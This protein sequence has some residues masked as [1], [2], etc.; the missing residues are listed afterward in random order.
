MGK[1][2]VIA[3]VQGLEPLTWVSRFDSITFSWIG[4]AMPT[5]GMNSEGL[6]ITALLDTQARYTEAD[7]LPTISI[8]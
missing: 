2:S 1:K 4:L 5:C 6:A 7:H 8:S 3:D